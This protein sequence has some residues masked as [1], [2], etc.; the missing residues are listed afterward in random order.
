MSFFIFCHSYNPEWASAVDDRGNVFFVESVVAANPRANLYNTPQTATSQRR[1]RLSP[2]LS[3]TYGIGLSVSNLSGPT[4]L[5]KTHATGSAGERRGSTSKSSHGEGEKRSKLKSMWKNLTGQRRGSV[6][7]GSTVAAEEDGDSRHLVS[8]MASNSRKPAMASTHERSLETDVV[9]ER[10]AKTRVSL[11][12]TIKM[13]GVL[14]Q[15]TADGTDVSMKALGLVVESHSGDC[16]GTTPGMARDGSPTLPRSTSADAGSYGDREEAGG[17]GLTAN[18]LVVA[19]V[20]SG[21]VAA[22]AL[23]GTELNKTHIHTG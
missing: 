11:N 19:K 16:L 10:S 20:I 22:L 21:S 12:F 15:P 2:S 18:G 13:S 14:A 3:F 7:A 17:M 8:D 1:S 5:N 4:V 9:P 6:G 23:A